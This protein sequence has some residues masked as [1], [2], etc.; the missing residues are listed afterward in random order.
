MA[1]TLTQLI[2]KVQALLGDTTGTFFT[3]SIVTAGIRQALSEWNLR[4]PNHI[5]TTIAAIADQYEY[6]LTD[7]ANVP[8]EIMD[9]L[10]RGDG[11]NELDISIGYDQYVEDERTFI[12]LR[13]PI[14]AN[15]VIIV[16]YTANHTIN[17]LDSALT[18]TLMAKD[19]QAMI[20]GGAFYSIVTRATARIETVNVSG[21]QPDDYQSIAVLYKASFDSRLG[22]AARSR[23]M[24][25]GEPDQRAW[26]DSYHNWDQ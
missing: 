11:N 26:N 25:V 15:E 4:A 22:L 20:D 7:A 24:P 3:T 18:S 17:G 13:A 5:A 23:R 8:I 6:E 16:R 10:E 12:R 2:T 1:D 21:G 19:D 14:T 9:V